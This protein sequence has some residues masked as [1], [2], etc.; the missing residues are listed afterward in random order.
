MSKVVRMMPV[1]EGSNPVSTTPR[2]RM[3][4]GQGGQTVL[5]YDHDDIDG[6]QGQESRYLT[7]GLN[8]AHAQA[9]QPG[10]VHGKVVEQGTPP[11][12]GHPR[13]YYEHEEKNVHPAFLELTRSLGFL[14]CGKETIGLCLVKNQV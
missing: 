6:Q 1:S 5:A 4:T 11:L 7:N 9:V 13:A 10:H 8:D 3:T 2:P 12:E 14:V